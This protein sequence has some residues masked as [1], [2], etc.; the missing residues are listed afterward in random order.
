MAVKRPQRLTSS[1]QL[2][3]CRTQTKLLQL[4]LTSASS[5]RRTAFLQLSTVLKL[6]TKS[7]SQL[8]A[9]KAGTLSLVWSSLLS[10]LYLALTSTTA[11]RF[12]SRLSKLQ[13]S[14]DNQF[15][16][17]P[18]HS[19][20]EWISKSINFLYNTQRFRLRWTRNSMWLLKWR[21][22]IWRWK[23]I[24]RPRA[25]EAQNSVEKLVKMISKDNS[26]LSKNYSKWGASIWT[27]PTS[28]NPTLFPNNPRLF[29]NNPALSVNNPLSYFK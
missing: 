3:S 14:N 8:R 23:P 2:H 13:R 18:V 1:Q 17:V 9:Q 16:R 10:Q 22:L 29:P 20:H 21:K 15:I 28:V 19:G 7:K 26:F 27:R 5:S 12:T 6:A 25:A 11:R 24:C 4:V